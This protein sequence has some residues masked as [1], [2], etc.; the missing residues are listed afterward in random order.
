MGVVELCDPILEAGVPFPEMVARK[1]HGGTCSDETNTV[2][3]P[4]WF[5]GLTPFRLT[6]IRYFPVFTETR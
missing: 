5:Q 1:L 2:Q 3:L 4:A 6:G